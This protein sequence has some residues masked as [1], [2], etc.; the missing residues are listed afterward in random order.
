MD[1]TQSQADDGCPPTS[2]GNEQHDASYTSRNSSM[3]IKERFPKEDKEFDELAMD[4][5]SQQGNA[6]DGSDHS[7]DEDY[8]Y[9]VSDEDKENKRPTK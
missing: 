7:A 8:A 2:V 9:N 4:D 5:Y 3:A 6:T 1:D